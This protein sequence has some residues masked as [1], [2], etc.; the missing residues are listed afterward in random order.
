[1]PLS[2]FEYILKSLPNRKPKQDFAPH[3][4]KNSHGDALVK[5]SKLEKAYERDIGLK[6]LGT[7]ALNIYFE[8]DTLS[9]NVIQLISYTVHTNT[10]S[11]NFSKICQ[12]F[13]RGHL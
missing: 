4:M 9:Q 8:V 2:C 13:P 1:M 12:I 11:V 6:R 7:T 3:P 10:F 5:D